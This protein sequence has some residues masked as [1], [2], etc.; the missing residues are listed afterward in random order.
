VNCLAS[1]GSTIRQRPTRACKR[2]WTAGALVRTP[3]HDESPP[4]RL[5]ELLKERAETYGR[6]HHRRD[7][8]AAGDSIGEIKKCA[9]DA[10]HLAEAGEA[11]LKPQPV[12]GLPA[13][14][15]YESWGRYSPLMPWNVPFWQVLALLQHH[16]HGRQYA[17]IKH[18]ET[19]QGSAEAWETW[20]AT[21]APE[22]LYLN[23]ATRLRRVRPSSP[24]RGCGAPVRSVPALPSSTWRWRFAEIGSGPVAS[25][26]AFPF[27]I[28]SA[29]L[30]SRAAWRGVR[31]YVTQR[32]LHLKSHRD[33]WHRKRWPNCI[34][35]S[36]L[37]KSRRRRAARPSQIGVLITMNGH[38]TAT[39]HF[40][41]DSGR[42]AATAAAGAERWRTEWPARTADRR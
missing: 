34:N 11:Y 24:I 16:S 36:L 31:L 25:F 23:L 17:I 32:R 21:P 15:I 30:R 13:Q 28:W 33:L 40:L 12:P 4:T 29:D 20:C 3:L 9:W 5:A 1:I 39:H 2:A 35:P 18:A 26:D 7:G 8:Q 10:R 27:M 42:S 41:A 22:G 37:L 6:P 38:G 19:V 14:I